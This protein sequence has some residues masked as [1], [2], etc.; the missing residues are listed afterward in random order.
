MSLHGSAFL[1]HAFLQFHSKIA[2]TYEKL[3][4]CTFF[5]VMLCFQNFNGLAI[6]C[7]S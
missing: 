6:F 4:A 3:L 5:D 1:N 7:V 2:D